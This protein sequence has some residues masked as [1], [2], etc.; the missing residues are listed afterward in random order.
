MPASSCSSH[1]HTCATGRA[2]RRAALALPAPD[3]VVPYRRRARSLPRRC[4]GSVANAELLDHRVEGAFARRDGSRRCLRC[5]RASRRSA[6][7]PVST[8]LGATNR[9]TA[10]GIDEAADQPGTGDA[11]DLGPGAGHPDGAPLPSRRGS[12]L[13]HQRRT[14][15]ASRLRSRLRGRGLIAQMPEPGG[16]AMAELEAALADDDCRGCAVELAAP[17]L[18]V[19]KGCGADEPGMSRGSAAKSS[20][21][22]TSMMMRSNGAVPTRRSS[23][24]TG[25]LVWSRTWGVLLG[26]ESGTRFFGMSPCGEIASPCRQDIQP[27]NGQVKMPGPRFDHCAIGRS[28]FDTK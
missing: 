27:Q 15:R 23:F 4:S 14:S 1:R 2:R 25:N 3:R 5:R 12:W 8:S 21:V 22:R 9:K 26:L 18:D 19:G 6:R 10:S 20:S 17:A 24:S 11:V 16:D 28:G 7:R 13:G